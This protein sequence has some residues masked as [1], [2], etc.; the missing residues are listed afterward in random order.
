MPGP[1]A[2]GEEKTLS[3][4]KT[5]RTVAAGTTAAVL[6]PGVA[7]AMAVG[8]SGKGSD[9]QVGE[10]VSEQAVV[11]AAERPAADDLAPSAPSPAIETPAGDVEIVDDTVSET[12]EGE[13][14]VTRPLLLRR[15]PS[16]QAPRSP[17]SPQTDRRA[18]SLVRAA[19]G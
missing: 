5:I 10:H 13:G 2:G 12:P 6:I 7:Y 8:G 11:Q 18:A 9:G 15:A 17:R 16:R 19:R 14:P 4:T 1:R 3:T